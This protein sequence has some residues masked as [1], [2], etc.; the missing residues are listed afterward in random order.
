MPQSVECSLFL[1]ADDSCL[2][3]QHKELSLIEEHLNRDFANICDWFVDNKLS[4]HFGEDK[5]KSILFTT[6]NKNK[7]VG[8]LNI[9]YNNINIKQY[10]R[11]TYLGCILDETLS[12]E[13]MALHVLNKLNTRLKFLC[14]KNELLSKPMRRLLCNALIQPHFDYACSAWYINLNKS[15]KAKLQVMQNKCIRFCLKLGKRTHIGAKDNNLNWLPVEQ[16]FH[17]CLCVNT[18]KYFN[19]ICPLYLKCNY[20]LQGTEPELPRWKL[21]ATTTMLPNDIMHLFRQLI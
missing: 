8:N 15:F 9:K 6:K 10:S 13:S 3:Y 16:R 20:I 7:S 17:Q 2:V 1:Y 14:R 18:F 12:G 19:D 4:I 11:V 21:A 5:T